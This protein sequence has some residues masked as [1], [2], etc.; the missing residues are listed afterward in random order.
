M[1]KTYSFRAV[2]RRLRKEG[3]YID[4]Q[5]GDHEQWRHPM[6]PGRRVTVAGPDGDDV[7]SGTLKGIFDQA[8]WDWRSR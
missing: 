6:K 1:P 7:K 5:D 4:R 8:G 3:W 2:R